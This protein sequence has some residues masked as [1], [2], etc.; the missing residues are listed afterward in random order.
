MGFLK[1]LLLIIFPCLFIAG[2]SQSFIKLQLP[3]NKALYYTSVKNP[4]GNSIMHVNIS[5][6]IKKLWDTNLH[7]GLTNTTAAVFDDYI[8]VNDLSGWISC[9]DLKERESLR[10]TQSSGSYLFFSI[11]L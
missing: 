5:D 2:C 11:D 10:R 1:K 8:F 7:G 4:D 6:S 3:G 9:L